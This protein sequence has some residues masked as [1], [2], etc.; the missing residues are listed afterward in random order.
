MNTQTHIDEDESSEF[1][2]EESTHTQGS[3]HQRIVS[4]GPAGELQF[5]PA[6]PHLSVTAPVSAN[7]TQAPYANKFN[8]NFQNRFRNAA[9]AAHTNPQ[10]I[11]AKTGEASKS[12]GISWDTIID[13]V[14]SKNCLT[15]F[16]H[17]GKTQKHGDYERFDDSSSVGTDIHK[18]HTRTMSDFSGLNRK[19][20]VHKARIHA[21]AASME[22]PIMSGLKP[23]NMG[24]ALKDAS[25][26]SPLDPNINRRTIPSTQSSTTTVHHEMTH[27]DST[28]TRILNLSKDMSTGNQN[29]QSSLSSSFNNFA[30]N[31]NHRSTWNN[32]NQHSPARSASRN[33]MDSM[34][35]MGVK[36]SAQRWNASSE[37]KNKKSNASNNIM[38]P[39]HD[40]VDL[41]DTPFHDEKV[42]SLKQSEINT[43]HRDSS[44]LKRSTFTF[45]HEETNIHRETP[46]IISKKS[47]L[48]EDDLNRNNNRYSSS[49]LPIPA[50]NIKGFR[51]FIDK[52][53]GTPA[54]ADYDSDSV[55]TASTSELLGYRNE[56]IQG[57]ESLRHQQK[58]T[59]GYDMYPGTSNHS[60][61][62]PISDSQLQPSIQH[63]T[64]SNQDSLNFARIGNSLSAIVTTPEA[65]QQRMMNQETFS[66]SES[67]WDKRNHRTDL[68]YDGD[69]PDF[70]KNN[71]DI[72]SS[73]SDLTAYAV[74]PLQVQ[75]FVRKYRKISDSLVERGHDPVL[76]EDA[77]KAFALFEMRSRIMETDIE[78]GIGRCGGTTIVDDM[79]ITEFYKQM[80]RVRDAVIVSKAWRDGASPKDAF[81]AMTLTRKAIT[82]SMRKPRRNRSPKNNTN[83]GKNSF[84]WVWEDVLWVDDTDFTLL[85]CPSLGPKSMRGSE[86]FTIGD[87]QSILLKITHERC[88]VRSIIIFVSL[89]L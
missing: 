8:G 47:S 75:A 50:N 79:V 57:I 26:K 19:D 2:L 37:S 22:H 27:A 4:H 1:F 83:P 52:T 3:T 21:V 56:S 7:H 29:V 80:Y 64:H 25:D 39:R 54:L 16:D 73:H 18:G 44:Q 82:F 76:Q 46:L 41:D 69:V 31:Q 24:K 11:A 40:I 86:I 30:T 12:V 49:T 43:T 74:D 15:P 58:A 85:R 20:L 42:Y 38:G 10:S 78:R 51:G 9:L 23:V 71:D 87:C 59:T 88:E 17:P 81:T 32:T 67:L 14:N 45:N 53:K 55:V 34:G 84:F 6:V 60:R 65:F 28:R 66:D 61:T 89:C 72:P 62:M 5:S 13:N 70:G 77:K 48:S 35:M 33:T 36:Q 63:V 68:A